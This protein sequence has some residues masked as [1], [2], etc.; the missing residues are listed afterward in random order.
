MKRLVV[1][2]TFLLLLGLVVACSDSGSTAGDA[3]SGAPRI[4]VDQENLDY[5]N[6]RLEQWVRPS[7]QIRNEGDGI[8]RIQKTTVKTIEGC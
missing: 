3:G 8:L 7:F 6:V 2:A 4:T 1:L 5:G